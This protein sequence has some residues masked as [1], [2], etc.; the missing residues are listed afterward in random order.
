MNNFLFLDDEQ[1]NKLANILQVFD[2]ILDV[3]QIDNDT[4]LAHLIEQDKVLDEQTKELQEQTN[5]YLKKITEQNKEIIHL[6][7]GENK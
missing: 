1:L 2:F 4:I 5:I 6:L 3:T 7:K